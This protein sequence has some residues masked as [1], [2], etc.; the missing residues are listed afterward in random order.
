MDIKTSPEGDG[1]G[2]G[3]VAKSPFSYLPNW[4]W[5]SPSCHPVGLYFG[6][7]AH[8]LGNQKHGG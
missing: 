3:S 5:H 7:L 4:E 1:A 2:K 6:G 8:A